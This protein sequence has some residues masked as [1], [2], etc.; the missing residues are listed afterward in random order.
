MNRIAIMFPL[1]EHGKHE[2]LPD[3]MWEEWNMVA[4]D[5]DYNANRVVVYLSHPNFPEYQTGESHYHY[6]HEDARRISPLLFTD[7]NPLLYRKFYHGKGWTKEMVYD[8]RDGF[9]RRKVYNKYPI[10]Y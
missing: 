3:M 9:Y 10:I 6:S 8:F 4:H 2:G 1:N 5:Y 7:T